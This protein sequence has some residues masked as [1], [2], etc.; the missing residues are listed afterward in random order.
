VQFRN[1]SSFFKYFV[2]KPDQPEYDFLTDL[3]FDD[4]PDFS[5]IAGLMN[6]S[7]PDLTPVHERRGKIL[8]WHGWADVGLNPL[9]TI[10]Y[11]DE[12][13]RTM[14]ETTRDDFMRLFMVPGMYHCTGGPGPNLFDDLGALEDW[15]ERGIAPEQMIARKAAP[16]KSPAR[17]ADK[18]AR[19]FVRS[20]PLCAYPKVSRYKGK[21]NIDSANN[22][23]CVNP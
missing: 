2:F 5:D 18:P 8:L 23:S 17:D 11:Y 7:D 22:F 12:V 3:D 10:S 4:V 9:A 1:G 6:A 16:G 15:V 13:G 19:D 20:R 21:G 14:G